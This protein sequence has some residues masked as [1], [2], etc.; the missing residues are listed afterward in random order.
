MFDII[1]QLYSELE[2]FMHNGQNVI[3]NSVTRS[4]YW[5]ATTRFVKEQNTLINMQENPTIDLDLVTAQEAKAAQYLD[6]L[7]WV[8]PQI[9]YT[10]GLKTPKVLVSGFFNGSSQRKQEGEMDVYF[11]VQRTGCTEE[12]AIAKI[13]ASNAAKTDANEA[14]IILIEKMVSDAIFGDVEDKGDKETRILNGIEYVD[15]VSISDAAC[16]ELL[17][18]FIQSIE[19]CLDKEDGFFT[20]E[21]YL[22]AYGDRRVDMASDLSHLSDL[23]PRLIESR[24]THFKQESETMEQ[25]IGEKRT[26]HMFQQDLTQRDFREIT[27]SVRRTSPAQAPGYFTKLGRALTGK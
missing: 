10:N 12:E 22:A 19:F 24:D 26:E 1:A 4:W 9:G 23:Y 27:G 8:F 16:K 14:R 25:L 7:R 3:Q 2:E 13:E 18:Q 20:D 21:K 15:E 6:I 11:L 17:D 5:M